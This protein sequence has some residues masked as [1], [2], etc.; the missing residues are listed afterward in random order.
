MA[1]LILVVWMATIIIIILGG[2]FLICE[3]ILAAMD[4]PSLLKIWRD[5]KKPL[6]D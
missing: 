1:L 4:K 3:L 5:S 6:P 2:I